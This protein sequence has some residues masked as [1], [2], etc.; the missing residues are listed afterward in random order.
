MKIENIDYEEM[1]LYI[2]L[3]RDE[4]YLKDNNMEEICPTRKHKNGRPT[5]TRNG[6]IRTNHE[7]P[8]IQI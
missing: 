2:K 6:V 7:K 3:N 8:H 1:G 5:I 4:K